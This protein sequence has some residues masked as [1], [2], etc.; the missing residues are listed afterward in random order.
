MDESASPALERTHLEKNDLDWLPRSYRAFRL[1]VT[2]AVWSGVLGGGL[3]LS[4]LAHVHGWLFIKMLSVAA[5]GAY[6]AGDRAARAALR[7][8]LAR[9]AHGQVDLSRLHGEPDGELVHVTGRVRALARVEG[10]L[11]AEP[12]CYRRT[13]L[14]HGSHRLIHE[15]A[16]DFWLV[17]DRG[18]PALV[19]VERA[20]LLPIDEKSV[21]L[22]HDRHP[23]LNAFM[24]LPLPA[25]TRAALSA[26]LERRERGKGPQRV[27]LVEALLRDGESVEIVGY[28]S[29][30]VDPS[31]AT[32]LGRDEPYRATLRG[33]QA[34]P[35][36]ISPSRSPASGPRGASLSDD[37]P[38]IAR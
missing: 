8:R 27:Q 16:Q 36:L 11:S 19:E 25:D 28:K 22:Q 18:E 4:S 3:A 10:L 15:M 38:P 6:V 12:A 26:S 13:I 2:G 9:L 33:G 30:V 24:A 5:G 32:R 1:G 23:A 34:L 29:R 17:A 14:R 35:L 7:A 31:V 21:V 37:C 20:R